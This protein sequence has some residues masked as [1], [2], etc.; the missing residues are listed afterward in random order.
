MPTRLIILILLLG[1]FPGAPTNASQTGQVETAAAVAC[2]TDASDWDAQALDVVIERTT[3]AEVPAVLR[4]PKKTT[5]P[6][7]VLWHGLGPPGDKETLMEALPL[8]DVPAVKVYL[9]L[10]LLG[11][12]LPSGGLSELSQRQSRD[13]GME[14]FAPIV[15]GA[16][17][18]LPSVV[19]ELQLRLG[20]A[21]NKSISL[22]GFSAGGAAVLLS[23][24]ERVVP[25]RSAV[26][27]NAPN[28]L[29]G[30]VAAFEKITGLTYSWTDDARSV[31][32]RTD[33]IARANDIAE[34]EPPPAILLIHGRSDEMIPPSTAQ[35][36]GRALRPY[37][38]SNRGGDRIKIDLW[39]NLEHHW[40]TQGPEIL[41]PLRQRIGTWLRC[42]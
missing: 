11:E 21:D 13:Y 26:I 34:I 4:I 37:Y 42:H 9:D 27:L 39:D 7:V 14:V 25:I 3:L 38:E 8:D 15:L 18:E 29:E 1:A 24:A 19:E 35:D 5:R 10:P 33:A 30:G 16:A 28:G 20:I 31:S 40:A 17:E 36:I 6:P 41:D 22:F 12:R 2:L 23:L 32:A